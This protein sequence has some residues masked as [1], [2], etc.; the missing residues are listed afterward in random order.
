M[1]IRLTARGMA[2]V[3]KTS[4]EGSA[5][6]AYRPDFRKF[7]LIRVD[8]KGHTVSKEKVMVDINKV[9]RVA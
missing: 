7:T 5:L 8:G 1:K 3:K 4:I 6:K 9:F 2:M